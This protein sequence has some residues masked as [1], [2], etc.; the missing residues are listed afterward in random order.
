MEGERIRVH[1]NPDFA[2]DIPWYLGLVKG[3]AERK[4]IQMRFGR[5]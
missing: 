1:A 3:Y 4:R 2:D 5:G